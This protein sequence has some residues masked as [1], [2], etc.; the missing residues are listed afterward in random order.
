MRD[1]LNL[2]ERVSAVHQYR[3]MMV[4][5]GKKITHAQIARELGYDETLVARYLKVADSLHKDVFRSWCRHAEMG[6]SF[7][8]IE[9]VATLKHEQQGPAF[10]ALFLDK[11]PLDPVDNTDI[12]QLGANIRLGV[13]AIEACRKVNEASDILTQGCSA[14]NAEGNPIYEGALIELAL[15]LNRVQDRLLEIGAILN[16]PKLVR[17][18]YDEHGNAV[19][20]DAHQ[21]KRDPHLTPRGLAVR[22]AR[23]KRGKSD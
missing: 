19:G 4:K 21:P 14:S 15:Q 16:G 6:V 2:P 1:R 10:M 20:E 5:A 13:A 18:G 17:R 7:V 8:E 23:R 9:R 12:S 11:G 3:D 22:D